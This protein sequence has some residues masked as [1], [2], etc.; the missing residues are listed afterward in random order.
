MDEG[1]R[2][3][4]G[5]LRGACTQRLPVESASLFH[6]LCSVCVCAYACV[7]VGRAVH[8]PVI[9]TAIFTG[10]SCSQSQTVHH[11]PPPAC[12]LSFTIQLCGR[13]L[14]PISP[15]VHSPTNFLLSSHI[16]HI[17][18]SISCIYASF[19][20]GVFSV[21]LDSVDWCG[22][23]GSAW[24][25]L[26][27]APSVSSFL[28]CLLFVQIQPSLLRT[29]EFLFTLEQW[30]PEMKQNETRNSGY[31]FLVSREYTAFDFREL[32]CGDQWYSS[33]RISHLYY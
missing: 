21:W 4:A 17:H 30:E 32:F 25:R 27:S 29:G 19:S 8:A 11:P 13:F 12:S 10:L 24:L 5:G 22:G 18:M 26:P 16:C 31:S 2:C 28:L 23:G 9:L 1:L 3:S 7:S 14:Y 15:L 6:S 33:L 20:S